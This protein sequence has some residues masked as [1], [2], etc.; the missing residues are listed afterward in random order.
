[1]NAAAGAVVQSIKQQHKTANP[2]VAKPAYKV[3]YQVGPPDP[4]PHGTGLLNP[5]SIFIASFHILSA[6]KSSWGGAAPPQT[7]ASRRM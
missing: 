1:M 7:E 3:S 6:N 2:P 4:S 5:N